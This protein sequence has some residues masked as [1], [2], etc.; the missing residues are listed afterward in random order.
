MQVWSHLDESRFYSQI[1]ALLRTDPESMCS[2]FAFTDNV[3][4]TV[5]MYKFFTSA[6]VLFDVSPRNLPRFIPVQQ[7]STCE[8]YVR[9]MSYIGDTLVRIAFA[10]SPFVGLEAKVWIRGEQDPVPCRNDFVLLMRCQMKKKASS[11]PF[12]H[13][14]QQHKHTVPS[15]T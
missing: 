15:K 3:Q 11:P 12:A 1:P 5:M 2:P 9:R 14:I 6:I 8:V 13:K 7:P 4:V 10:L